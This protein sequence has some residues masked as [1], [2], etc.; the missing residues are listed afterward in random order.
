[1]GTVRLLADPLE[2][3]Q[4][5]LRRTGSGAFLLDESTRNASDHDILTEQTAY[6]KVLMMDVKDLKNSQREDRLAVENRIRDLGNAFETRA[7]DF[8]KS[9]DVRFASADA[10]VD[11]RFAAMDGRVRPL[12]SAYM[13]AL[14]AGTVAGSVAAVIVTIATKLLVK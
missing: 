1:M 8:E 9:V 7:R 6:L 13:K 12:E 3:R 4:I 11:V 5:E 14:G 2:R 10:R